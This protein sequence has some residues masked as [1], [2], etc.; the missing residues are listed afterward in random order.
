MLRIE[1]KQ[2][3]M[4]VWRRS[5]DNLMVN[6]GEVL[7]FDFTLHLASTHAVIPVKTGIHVDLQ[8]PN[9]FPPSRE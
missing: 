4:C 5:A 3:A 2:F 8:S 7:M 1:F 6:C 9:G